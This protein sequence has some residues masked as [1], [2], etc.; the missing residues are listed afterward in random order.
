M[1]L[2][3]SCDSWSDYSED[4]IS[5]IKESFLAVKDFNAILIPSDQ[6]QIFLD[7]ISWYLKEFEKSGLHEQALYEDLGW[8]IKVIEIIY[9]NDSLV[10][11][12]SSVKI[13]E[14][15]LPIIRYVNLNCSSDT[16]PI[17]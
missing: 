9:F 2:S 10:F 17:D 13:H 7:L 3:N 4:L 5:I 6:H 11:Q 12:I 15:I 1:N 16:T 8:I 14:A